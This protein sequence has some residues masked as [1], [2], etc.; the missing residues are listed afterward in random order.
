[1]DRDSRLR[2]AS[3][4]P[5]PARSLSP[6]RSPRANKTIAIDL[7]TLKVA[8]SFDV[9]QLPGEILIR[10]DAAVAYITCMPPQNRRPRPPHLALQPTI[11]LTPGVDGMAW[12]AATKHTLFLCGLCALRPLCPRVKFFLPL[13][14]PAHNHLR[15]A[16]R[17]APAIAQKYRP[18]RRNAKPVAAQS[19]TS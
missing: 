19:S 13:D 5:T 3:D 1:M 6:S 10:P 12:S 8:Q 2:Y 9:P 15:V 11:D 4:T 18:H 16:P 17:I 14:A 7:Q